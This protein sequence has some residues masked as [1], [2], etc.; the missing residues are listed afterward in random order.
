MIVFGKNAE[1]EVPPVDFSIQLAPQIESLLDPNYTNLAGAMQR[2]M[3]LFPHDT[4]KRIVLVTDGNQNIGDALEEARAMADAGVSIDV[5]PVPLGAS[6]RRG[7]R[8]GGA[9]AGYS[10]QSAV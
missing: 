7:G 10:A 6:E 5:M 2:A 8:E 1:V 3:S 9:A 4:A